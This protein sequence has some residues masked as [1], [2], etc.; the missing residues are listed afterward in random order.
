MRRVRLGVL[1]RRTAPPNGQ[2]SEHL[3]DASA[4]RRDDAGHNNN[5]SILIWQAGEVGT[6]GEMPVD[7][8]D[9]SGAGWQTEGLGIT[10]TTCMLPRRQCGQIRKD[11][12]FDASCWSR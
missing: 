3:T 9:V 7:N 5:S 10:S 11:T 6:Y 2:H 4:V 12:P 8:H 1:A